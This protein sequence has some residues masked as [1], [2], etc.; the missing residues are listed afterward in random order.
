MKVKIP[1]K[2]QSKLR[3]FFRS[4]HLEATKLPEEAFKI[5]WS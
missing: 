4:G 1:R 3:F 2:Y 5:D